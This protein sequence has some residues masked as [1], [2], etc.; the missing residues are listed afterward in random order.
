MQALIL[1][2]LFNFIIG[3]ERNLQYNQNKIFKHHKVHQKNYLKSHE[4]PA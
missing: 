4:K 2:K 3:M 1:Q